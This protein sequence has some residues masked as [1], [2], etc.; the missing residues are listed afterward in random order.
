MPK[1]NFIGGNWKCN[2]MLKDA[3]GL[4]K[5]VYGKLEFDSEK[6]DVVCSP[7]ML[8]IPSV[9]QELS[10]SKVKVAAQNASLSGTGAYTGEVS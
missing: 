7:I 10:N 4:A 5:D 2:L 3:T 6:V 8:Q 1:R 9:L